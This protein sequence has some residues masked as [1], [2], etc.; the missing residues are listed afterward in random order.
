[1]K[2]TVESPLPTEEQLLLLKACLYSDKRAI[3]FFEKWLTK[4]DLDAY[5]DHGSFRLLPLLYKNLLQLNY[6]G[7]RMNMLK[8]IYRKSWCQNQKILYDS[9]QVLAFFHQA[10]IETIVLKGV[11]LSSMVY[12]DVGA[13]PMA[14]LDVLVPTQKAREAINLLCSNDWEA[15]EEIPEEYLDYN[16]RYGKSIGFVNPSDFECD[17]HWQPFYQSRSSSKKTDFWNKKIP[18]TIFSVKT[19]SLSYEDML[20]HS[21]VHGMIWNIEPPIRWI[22]DAY[23]LIQSE[24]ILLDWDYIIAQL[25]KYPVT[26]QFKNGLYYLKKEFEVEI[27]SSFLTALENIRI[28]YGEKL[29][30]QSLQQDIENHPDKLFP[31]LNK[32]F[33]LYLQQAKKRNIVFHFFGFIRHLGVRPERKRYLK[34]VWHFFTKPFKRKNRR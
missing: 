17:I 9:A 23:F 24:H 31:T 5:I 2:N 28:T 14:D 25:K 18:T 3:A 7:N 4:V 11:A 20:I 33:I 22:A 34:N 6:K 30:F 27:P 19:H 15:A 8:G 26:L 10:G 29:V 21:F 13:R 32:Y 1:M 16:I 12:K